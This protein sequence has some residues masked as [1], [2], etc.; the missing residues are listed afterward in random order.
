VHELL[1]AERVVVLVELCPGF[2][3]NLFMS[4]RFIAI[5]FIDCKVILKNLI[6]TLNHRLAFGFCCEIAE[7]AR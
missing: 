1:S 2:L 5:H 6:V 4:N 3:S 7:M